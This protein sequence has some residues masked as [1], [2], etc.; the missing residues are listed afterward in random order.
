VA[1]R[2]FTTT[3]WKGYGRDSIALVGLARSLMVIAGF[4][5]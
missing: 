1:T 5:V 2:L 3:F 4:R